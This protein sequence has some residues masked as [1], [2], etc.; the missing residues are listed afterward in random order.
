VDPVRNPYAP[1]AGQQ[2]PE[3][4]GRD[5]ELARVDVLLERAAL[6]RPARG[7]VLS[8]LRGVGK[9]VLL[10]AMRSRALNAGWLTGKVEA[11]P[12]VGLRAPVGSALHGA[13]REVS[14]RSRSRAVAQR[15]FAVLSSFTLTAGPDGMRLGLTG[16]PAAGRADSG[17]FELDLTDL[18][19]DLTDVARDLGVGVALFVDELQDVPHEDLVALCGACHEMGQNQR[20][21]LLVGAGLPTLP[22]TL[23]AARSY[24]ERLFTYL[25]IDRL[26]KDAVHRALIAPA[27]REG[28]S[29]TDDALAALAGL[30]DGYPYFLQS[31]GKATWDAALCTPITEADVR[32]GQP[33]ADVDLGA[34]FFGSRYER[35]TRAERDYMR[36][37]AD[38]GDGPVLTSAVAR[39]MRRSMSALSPARDGLIRKGLAYSAERGHIAFTVPHFAAFLRSHGEQAGREAATGVVSRAGSL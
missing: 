13:V 15:L 31:Y 37:M 36:A 22:A 39:A 9:T 35:A 3:L 19:T 18:F 16:T 34:G 14:A 21:F 4:A 27:A 26:D 28:V 12:Q 11:R 24:A 30:A 29:F 7:L 1:G 32:A 10:N 6:G 20:P 33:Q 38:L 5:D 25:P 17:D 2:P 8:G 23:S